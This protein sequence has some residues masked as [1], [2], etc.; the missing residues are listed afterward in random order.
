MT[1][2]IED[3]K[4]WGELHSLYINCVNALG[5][6]MQAAFTPEAEARELRKRNVE[7]HEMAAHLDQLLLRSFDAG[8]FD[9]SLKEGAALDP[10]GTLSDFRK[11]FGLR[12]TMTA[13]EW[14]KDQVR[15]KEASTNG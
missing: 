10:W 15:D 11:V 4:K 9:G 5:E 12:P 13:E 3:A 14:V 1:E 8:M 2:T 6:L 7:M